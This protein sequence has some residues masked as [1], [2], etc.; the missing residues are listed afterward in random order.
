MRRQ[1]AQ[2]TAGQPCA[3]CVLDVHLTRFQLLSLAFS[4]ACGQLLNIMHDVQQLHMHTA[5]MIQ[6]PTFQAIKEYVAC[7][8]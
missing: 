7:T 3:T 4:L 6:V 8:Y 2:I 1:T 5:A